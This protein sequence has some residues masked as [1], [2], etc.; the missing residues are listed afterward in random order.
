MMISRSLLFSLPLSAFAYSI[1]PLKSRQEITQGQCQE[2]ICIIELSPNSLE[3]I[4]CNAVPGADANFAQDCQSIAGEAQDTLSAFT[5]SL[6]PIA[7]TNLGRPNLGFSASS[8]SCQLQF[9]LDDSFVNAQSQIV[10]DINSFEGVLQNIT[11]ATLNEGQACTVNVMR[12]ST[13]IGTASTSG[14]SEN[15][16]RST[17]I[18]D[19]TPNSRQV[20]RPRQT[21]SGVDIGNIGP[22]ILENIQCRPVPGLSSDFPSDCMQNLGSTLTSLNN[23]FST[24]IVPLPFQQNSRLCSLAFS[25]SNPTANEQAITDLDSFTNVFNELINLTVDNVGTV[26]TANVVNKQSNQIV[27]LLSVSQS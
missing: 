26:C 3:D 7:D 9:V 25:V 20:V 1:G 17:S 14:V 8:G 24:S 11:Q 15:Q 6:A 27:G 10:T 12:G 5:T 18:I 19:T 23:D 2:S 13:M 21:S 22:N 4:Q 16:R